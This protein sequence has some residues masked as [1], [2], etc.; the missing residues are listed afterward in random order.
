MGHTLPRMKFMKSFKFEGHGFMELK[1]LVI[2]KTIRDGS[3]HWNL[4]QC[5][6]FY[7]WNLSK[8][9]KIWRSWVGINSHMTLKNGKMLVISKT[10]RNTAKRNGIWNPFGVFTLTIYQNLLRLWVQIATRPRINGKAC[11]VEN[12]KWP[13]ETDWNSNMK[14]IKILKFEGHGYESPHD[15]EEWKCS[16]WKP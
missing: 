13:R 6:G 5:R 3:K 14:C 1:M 10:V 9:S 8:F 11:Y 15:L 16:S 2:L 7:I 4:E 12:H